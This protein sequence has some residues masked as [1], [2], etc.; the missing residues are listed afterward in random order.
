MY[1]KGE[2][3]LGSILIL[4]LG[5][6][7][8]ADAMPE[9]VHVNHGK[10]GLGMDRFRDSCAFQIIPADVMPLPIFFA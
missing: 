7:D 8:V 1:H 10:S 9:L 2:Q 5:D 6:Q 4:Y 3:P